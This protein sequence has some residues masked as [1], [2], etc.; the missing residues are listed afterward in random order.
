MKKLILALSLLAVVG[1]ASAQWHPH[2]HGYRGYGYS[3]WIAPALVGGVI[4][5]ELSRP[6]ETV[7]VQQPP[8]YVQPAPTTVY[9]NPPGTLPPP[10]G[11]HFAQMID[12][13]T[14]QYTIVLVPN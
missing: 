8:V 7:I 9:V 13:R 11:Y 10:A 12:P 3:G 5:Y 2:N 1:S 6:R 4:G 14:N